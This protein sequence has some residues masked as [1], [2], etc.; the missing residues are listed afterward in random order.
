[1]FTAADAGTHTF[2]AALYTAGTGKSITATDAG[3]AAVTGKQT[4]ITVNPGDAASFNF[5]LPTSTTA[6]MA[7]NATLTAKDGYANVA[8]G[9]A[10]T[11]DFISSDVQAMLPSDYTFGAADAGAHT[12]TFTLDTAGSR[13]INVTDTVNASLTK[14]STSTVNPAAASTLSVNGPT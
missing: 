9:Y 14:T 11:V 8:T 13:S 5:T 7:F 10:G 12:F 6:G 1:T 3:V 4:G 2:S